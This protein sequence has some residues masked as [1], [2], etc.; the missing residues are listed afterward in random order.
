[1]GAVVLPS[2]RSVWDSEEEG[3][4]IDPI[5][6]DGCPRGERVTWG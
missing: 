1:M 3:V 4:V 2:D 6:E 5:L